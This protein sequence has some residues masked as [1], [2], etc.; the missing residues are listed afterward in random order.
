MHI[1]SLHLVPWFLKA[2]RQIPCAAQGE[3]Q[4]MIA[5]SATSGCVSVD[6]LYPG[7]RVLFL[8]ADITVSSR[9]PA[10]YLLRAF[11]LS[12]YLYPSLISFLLFF[13]VFFY[14]MLL[15]TP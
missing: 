8:S 4:H 11:G 13:S 2:C 5:A 10:L 12:S 7:G 6:W 3:T 15:K 14:C 9:T 1:L